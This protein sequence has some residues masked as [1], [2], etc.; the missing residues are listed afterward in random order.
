MKNMKIE[1]IKCPRCDN[2]HMIK[3]L[4]DDLD[5]FQCISCY[6][7]FSKNDTEL[8]E[9]EA[10]DLYSNNKP[11]SSLIKFGEMNLNL[12]SNSF[13]V[14]ISLIFLLFLTMWTCASY[15]EGTLAI[16][17]LGTITNIG[18]FE[19][20]VWISTAFFYYVFF[21]TCFKFSDKFA[22]TFS[23][24]GSLLA[25]IKWMGDDKSKI[26]ITNEKYNRL[27]TKEIGN[28]NYTHGI[29]V[30]NALEKIISTG[31]LFSLI[32][33]GIYLQHFKLPIINIWHLGHYPLGWTTWF[34]ANF[35]IMVIILPPLLSRF[36]LLHIS[37]FKLT[38]VSEQNN[39]EHGETFSNQINS[40]P[41]NPNILSPDGVAGMKPLG[42]LAF[43]SYLVGVT[44]MIPI[45][46]W[47]IVREISAMFLFLFPMALIFISINLVL[48]LYNAHHV[49]KK[50]KHTQLNAIANEYRIYHQVFLD[51]I[52]SD[53]DTFDEGMDKRI[54]SMEHL[55]FIYDNARKASEWPIDSKLVRDVVTTVLI[56]LLLLLLNYA[57]RSWGKNG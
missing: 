26:G 39:H 42:D 15:I 57:L 50:A 11:L 13:Y 1:S 18:W 7:E 37:I 20:Y 55:N 17:N 48:P 30:G 56:P 25:V 23:K 28:I 31:A 54:K 3:R 45:I 36:F 10:K 35:F 27:I 44:A 43:S 40:L 49:M 34:I 6:T 33:T 46:T 47:I 29:N 51:R 9:F 53:A 22:T 24:N 16:E 52:E 8:L 19:D 21:M 12:K 38:A 2:L 14:T 41:F 32:Y 5:R 4:A